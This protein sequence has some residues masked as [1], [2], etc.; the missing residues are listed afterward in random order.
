MLHEYKAAESAKIAGKTEV[1]DISHASNT[2]RGSKPTLRKIRG[3]TIDAGG[4]TSLS[5]SVMPEMAP[6]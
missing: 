1:S 6:S 3:A 5:T 2:P 4:A